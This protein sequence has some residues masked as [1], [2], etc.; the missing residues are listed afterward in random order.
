MSGT[1][2]A[3]A[4]LRDARALRET[5]AA[6]PSPDPP[7]P[8]GD[9]RPRAH[10]VERPH[11]SDVVELA[12]VGIDVGSATYHLTVS[13]V[14]LE[15]RA[16]DLSTRYEVVARDVLVVSPVLLTPYL[17][18]GGLID[19]DAVEAT[20]RRCYREAG[21]EPGDVDTGV[22]LLTGAAL[23]RPNARALADR[24][25]GSSGR[26]V[27]AAAGH[28]FEA[29]LAAHGSGAVA[30]SRREG[31]PV[32]ALDVGGA[33]TKLAVV[34]GGQV[35]S[36]AAL[37]AGGRLVAW[38]GDGHLTRVEPVVRPV[39]RRLGVD[40]SPGADVDP[41]AI[42]ALAAHLAAAVVEQL[43]P[44]GS[45]GGTGAALLLSDPLSVPEEAFELVPSGGVAEYLQV[46]GGPPA[47]AGGSARAGR[48]GGDDLG[49]SLAR[50][51]LVCLRDAGLED[52]LRVGTQR[53]RATV[54]GASQF[55]TQVSGST[56]RL[57]ARAALPLHNVP[58][59]RPSL[60]LD[61]TVDPDQVADAVRRALVERFEGLASPPAV[62]LAV[63]WEG[64]PDHAR[65]RALADGIATGTAGLP[66][67][68]VLVV[69]VDHDVAASLGRLM[70]EESGADDRSLV[71]LDGLELADL[72]HL[73]VARP[74]QPAKVVPVVVKSLLFG[75]PPA[76]EADGA[77][78]G[79][80][81][82]AA[83]GVVPPS[84]PGGGRP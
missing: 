82:H 40:L 37:S 24:L 39:A 79:G 77:V 7:T 22:V 55:S 49:P 57:G 72:D 75:A 31:R 83:G 21:V 54:V 52:R 16:T 33:T 29:I 35:R 62:A 78:A 2:A 4:A 73:D 74:V 1:T 50:W 14:R 70:V 38:D 84:E 6:S 61:G 60:A 67:D 48:G 76:P 32:V 23:A 59:V 19:A 30:R 80:L 63:A 66:A 56:T 11:D 15:R 27:C 69:A 28:H 8:P 44:A 3:G 53:I 5:P 46:P 13:T 20:A 45:R 64:L 41:A 17:D 36:T 51:L 34:D 10:L 43:L 71:V 12:T 65:L 42:E 26:L 47:A 9:G 25:A 18:G 68:T 81:G 58:V